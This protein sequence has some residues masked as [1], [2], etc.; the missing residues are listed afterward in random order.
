MIWF[1]ASVLG[2]IPGI[3]WDKHHQMSFPSK[4]DLLIPDNQEISAV[5]NL[6]LSL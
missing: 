2:V 1:L 3:S 5:D 6:N 4:N